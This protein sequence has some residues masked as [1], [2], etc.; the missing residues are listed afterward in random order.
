MSQKNQMSQVSQL[1]RKALTSQVYTLLFRKVLPY[2]AE[3]R[4]I[5]QAEHAQRLNDINRRRGKHGF[6]YSDLPALSLQA[7]P[8][9]NE[10]GF[11]CLVKE[12][13]FINWING[14]SSPRHLVII[15]AIVEYTREACA[16]EDRRMLLKY[17][18]L[19]VLRSD[20]FL[21]YADH[22]IDD[23][24]AGWIA[25][26][27]QDECDALYKALKDVLYLLKNKARFTALVLAEQAALAHAE[28][29]VLDNPT[30]QAALVNPTE[31]AA[32]DNP[33]EWA[34]LAGSETE[35][36][37]PASASSKSGSSKSGSSESGSSESELPASATDAVESALPAFPP[38]D[39]PEAISR[40]S[41]RFPR[42]TLF[43]RLTRSTQLAQIA[44]ST[45]R[46]WLAKAFG[47]P[48]GIVLL[49]L[50][51]VL[52]AN[53]NA[54]A[55]ATR[56]DPLRFSAWLADALG[57]D[58]QRPV[59]PEILTPK[60]DSLRPS[61]SIEL[62]WT[63]SGW[64]E[65]Y[66]VAVTDTASWQQ[67]YLRRDIRDTA[68][69]LDASLFRSGGQYRLFVLSA[70]GS[71]ETAPGYVDIRIEDLAPPTISAPT[72]V[73][74][75][76]L[77][78]LTVRWDAVPEADGYAIEVKDVTTWSTLVTQTSVQDTQFALDRSLFAAGGQY[79]IYV[80]SKRGQIT[81]RPSYVTVTFER[82]PAK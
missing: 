36:E 75:L 9:A 56:S 12:N 80:L 72:D 52:L 64:A 17:G 46:T 50:V 82:E 51:L 76:P 41:G 71:E 29:A 3:G 16:D 39:H 68:V 27:G 69:T 6:S 78:D 37:S 4:K 22:L 59:P 23:A 25:R 66:A 11:D 54:Y 57:I 65:T 48:A 74:L 62:T 40:T 77:S 8:G 13:N 44:H 38:K 7:D 24:V 33:L 31:Q 79:R 42:L 58:A 55:S 67:I 1:Q 19:Q 5:G 14:I 60:H 43:S 47:V 32:L 49:F 63:S 53:R 30:E 35:V 61:G 28:R 81:S 45:R 18:L 21:G 2:V 20:D 34:D 26:I 70:R 10:P 73:A 15:N